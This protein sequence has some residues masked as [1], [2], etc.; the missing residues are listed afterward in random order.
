MVQGGQ[1]G[2]VGRM[3]QGGQGGQGGHGGKGETGDIIVRADE[4]SMRQCEIK[5]IKFSQVRT[6]II[7]LG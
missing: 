7:A 5:D 3:G 4:A 6:K 2:P 1:I